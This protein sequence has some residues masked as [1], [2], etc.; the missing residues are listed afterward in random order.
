MFSKQEKKRY[1]RHFRLKEVGEKGQKALKNAK[2][3]VVGA[4]GL[5]CPVLQYLT[6]AGLGKIGIIDSDVID[7]SNLQRQVLYTTD[8]IGKQKS[9]IAISRL[10]AQNNFVRFYD[11]A[12]KLEKENVLEIITKYDVVVDCTDNFSARYL[13]N[14]ACV[15]LDKPFVYGALHKFSG[16]LSVFNYKEGPTYR[17]L[18]PNPPKD[19]DIPTCSEVGVIG[20]LP[21]LIGTLQAIEVL[22]I[23]L[24]IGDVLCGKLLTYNS[25]SNVQKI[26]SILKTDIQITQLTSYNFDCVFPEN[27]EIEVEILKSWI[28]TNQQFNIIDIREQHEID[29]SRLN[30]THYIPMGS[31]LDNLEEIDFKIPTIIFCQ[32]G[33]KSKAIVS[34]LKKKE[35]NKV[36]SLAGGVQKWIEQ[37][38]EN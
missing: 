5:G 12:I 33:A 3:L 16:Q 14:D 31:F 37:D 35:I 9:T 1:D 18:Y 24:N 38:L 11:Y 6:S 23:I 27:N 8:D 19:G 2:V 4:G 32:Y 17:C 10:S 34:I 26:I 21:S 7:T 15:L 13:I 30:A 29:D 36:F 25:M 22:K 20:V 28:E